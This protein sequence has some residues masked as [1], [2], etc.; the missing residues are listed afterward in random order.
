MN[1]LVQYTRVKRHDR[2]FQKKKEKVFSSL[3]Q[4]VFQDQQNN[5]NSHSWHLLAIK[6]AVNRSLIICDYLP[7]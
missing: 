6:E 3:A 5:Y 4:S 7:Y 1:C 2:V